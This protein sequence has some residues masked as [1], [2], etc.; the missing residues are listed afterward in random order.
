M[1]NNHHE[2]NEGRRKFLKGMAVAGALVSSR[3]V[4]GAPLRY[5]KPTHVDNPLAYY[6]NRD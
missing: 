1:S 4:F 2:A 3:T 6:P 5:F